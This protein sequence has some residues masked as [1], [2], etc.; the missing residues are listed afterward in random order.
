MNQSSDSL[1]TAENI[2]LKLGQQAGLENVS[3]AIRTEEIVTL[4]GPNGAG[5]TTLVH[6]LLGIIKPDTGKIKRKENLRVGYVPQKLATNP[7]MPMTVTRFLKMTMALSDEKINSA[8]IEVGASKVRDT[9]VAN[10]SGGELQRIHI[11]R[12]LLRDPDLLILDEPTQNV[13]YSGQA[14]LYALISKIRNE[15]KCGILLISHDLHLVM[16]KTDHVLCLNKHVCCE[17]QP[18]AVSRHPEYQALF[19]PNVAEGL[20]VYSHQ[21]DHQ[22]NFLKK[23]EHVQS[24]QSN[25]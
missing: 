13:D 7:N 15:R 6:I 18:E 1:I 21:H 16:S 25:D 24:R 10:L 17:G 8:L 5:K 20:A 23:A 4:I 19:G 11:A 2:S 22:H 14:E 3:V 12:A 9:L